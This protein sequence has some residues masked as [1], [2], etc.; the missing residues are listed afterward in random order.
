M[1]G[2]PLPNIRSPELQEKMAH[3]DQTLVSDPSVTVEPSCVKIVFLTTLCLPSFTGR[4]Q[5]LPDRQPYHC[6]VLHPSFA[7]PTGDGVCHGLQGSCYKG[8]RVES[9]ALPGPRHRH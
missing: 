6:L 5:L 9:R 8:E 3:L 1:V 2:M 7:L 4:R